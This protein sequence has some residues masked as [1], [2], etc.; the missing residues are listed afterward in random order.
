MA[1]RESR[2]RSELL[3]EAARSYI[4]RKER[5]AGIFALGRKIARAKGLKPADVSSEIRAH[6]KSKARRG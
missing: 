6:R 1:R 3:R 2:S 4:Q 5:W